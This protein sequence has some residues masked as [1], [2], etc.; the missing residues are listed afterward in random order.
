MVES[1]SSTMRGPS[2]VPP[3]RSFRLTMGTLAQPRLVPKYTSRWALVGPL[4]DVPDSSNCS[5]IRGTS[6]RPR[7][8]TLTL[9][10]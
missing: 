3:A 9:T 4:L 1:Y 7:A 8:M 2:V 10:S 6:G 5:G